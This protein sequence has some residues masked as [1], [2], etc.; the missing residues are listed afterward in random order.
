[1]TYITLGSPLVRPPQ[2]GLILVIIMK[3]GNILE[4]ID[5]VWTAMCTDIE[6]SALLSVQ[7]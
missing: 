4:Q 7:G 6:D 1:M 3:N 5:K 2:K